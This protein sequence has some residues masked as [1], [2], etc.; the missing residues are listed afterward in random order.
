MSDHH[1]KWEPETDFLRRLAKGEIIYGNGSPMW[2]LINRL[3]RAN[4]VRVTVIN[5]YTARVTLVEHA[6]ECDTL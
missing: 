5:R 3:S 2:P 4:K 6:R 1:H